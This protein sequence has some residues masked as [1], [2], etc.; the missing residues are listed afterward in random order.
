MSFCFYSSAQH[1][2]HP[3]WMVCEM[4]GK[5]P[6]SYWVLLPGCVQNSTHHPCV[7]PILLFL[8]PVRWTCR[9]EFAIP[10]LIKEVRPVNEVQVIHIIFTKVP[11]TPA[12]LRWVKSF[13]IFWYVLICCTYITW[14]MYYHVVHCFILYVIWKPHRWTYNVV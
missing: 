12:I 8:C 6:Y 5:W 14:L 10:S 3:A 11:P 1:I 13:A 2:W 9:L 7:V 4:G